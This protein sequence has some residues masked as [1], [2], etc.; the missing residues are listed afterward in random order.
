MSK[1]P[2][3]SVREQLT[4]VSAAG[5]VVVS[6]GQIEIASTTRVELVD[7]TDRIAACVRGSGVREGLLSLWSPHTTCAL[8][9]NERQ[10]ALADDILKLLE[11]LVPEDHDY[12]HNDP[13]YSDCD[14]QNADAHLRAL[15]LGQSLT[16]QVSGGEVAL[17]RWQRV[18][19]AELDGP[20]TRTIRV[21]VMGVNAD[22]AGR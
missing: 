14:R 1:S 16:L 2:A 5:G 21:Q 22:G 4:A 6:A 18:L 19:M 20:R 9:V 8:V 12:R 7:V 13:E 15:L 11:R 10:D 17:G 3:P